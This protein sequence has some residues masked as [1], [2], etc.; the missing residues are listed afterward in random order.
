M[1]EFNKFLPKVDVLIERAEKIVSQP[2]YVIKEA[3]N[4]MLDDQRKS[5]KSNHFQKEQDK[6]SERNFEK[7][8]KIYIDK[9][10]QLP[11]KR[12]IN[13]TGT[14]IHTNLGRA[15]LS[16]RIV[17]EIKPLIC[18]YSDLEFNLDTGLR[19]SRL[20][21][22]KPSLFGSEDILVVNN[23]A[24]ACLLVL[25]TI[26]CGKEVIVSRGELVEIGGSFR[27][28]EIMKC[29]GA[30]LKEVGTTNKTH[31]YDY[32][33]A[34]NDNTG[35]ILKVHRSNFVQKGFVKEVNT[36]ELIKLSLKYKIPFYFDAGSGACG[37][38]RQ[39]S[40]D[41][42]VI[43]EE[44]KKGVDIVS[45][46]GDKL[47][48]GTQ[49]GLIVGK[50]VYIDEMKKNPLYRALR[51]D[52]FTIYY[53]ERL[54]FY[55]KRGNYDAS[56]VIK[57]LIEPKESIKSRAKKFV[58]LITGKIHKHYFKLDIDFSTPGGGSLP[59]LTLETVVLK[60]KHPKLSEED[61][62]KSLLKSNPPVVVR[63]KENACIIDF[64]TVGMEEIPILADVL[65]KLF[66]H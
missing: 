62:S 40:M 1:N 55:L 18:N 16:E 50:K 54:F 20:K 48:G 28:P 65:I 9:V 29:S 14:V 45:F 66:N 47:L 63:R 59:E 53:L 61:L 23:N 2:R 30:I 17:D 41:E 43:E 24:S 34:I 36:E 10:L 5:I 37:I 19:G 39:I 6:F 57:M 31:I 56:P 25:N 44:I 49:A 27:V 21:H 33:R 26:A 4:L 3:I 32:E 60:I 51:P 64:R 38:I 11:V 12:I 15:P 8:L 35:L 58:K 22:I 52:K 42:P 46:S 13:A 7:E